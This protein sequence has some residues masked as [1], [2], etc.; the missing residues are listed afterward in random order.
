MPRTTLAGRAAIF[1]LFAALFAAAAHAEPPK[2][3]VDIAPVHSLVAQVMEGVAAPELLLAQDANPHAVQ[4]RPSQARMLADA[5]LLIWVGPGLSP[6]LQRLADGRDGDQIVLMD[7][8]ATHLRA[9]TAPDGDAP[10]DHAGEGDDGHSA[11]DPHVWL[12]VD[13]ARAWLG[14]FAEDLAARDPDNAAAYRAN[15]EKAQAGI[16]ALAARIDARLAAHHGAEI[17][18]FHAS[19]GYF[20]DR[21]GLVVAGSVRPGDAATPSAAAIAALKELVAVHDIACAFAEPAFDPGLLDTIAGD[22]GLRIGTLDTTGVLQSPGPG[23]YAATLG[24]VADGIADCLE[25]T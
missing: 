22:T 23:Q 13:N 6:W 12:S 4:L 7:D 3:V 10:D 9:F 2:V 11:N 15:A 17:V 21:F 5:D 8:P 1:A 25:G 16:D 19:L 18:T 20:A 14:V 24:A